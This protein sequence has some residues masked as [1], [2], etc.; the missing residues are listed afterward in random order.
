[1]SKNNNLRKYYGVF[2]LSQRNLANS[3]NN[4]FK[5]SFHSKGNFLYVP[6]NSK[7]CIVAH[8]DTVHKEL[9]KKVFSSQTK[10]GTKIFSKEGI[11]AD[12]RC[13]IIASLYIR[14]Q[15][16]ENTP[17]IVNKKWTQ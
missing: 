10:K 11:G 2:M 14:E 5:D 16:K 4:K 8:L 15:L 17:G 3:L 6:G 7:V 12:D 13:G 1:M 9:P